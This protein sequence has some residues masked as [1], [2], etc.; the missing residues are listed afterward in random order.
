LQ[1]GDVSVA[2]KSWLPW[3]GSALLLLA[4]LFLGYMV[5]SVDRYVLAAVLKPMSLDLGIVDQAGACTT[6]CGVLS[7]AQYV[8]VALTVFAAGYLSDRYGTRRIIL[9]GVVV[10]SAFTWLVAFS[11]DFSQAFV[12]RLISGAGEGLFWP[13]AMSAAANYFGVRKGLALGIFY[14][15]FDVGQSTGYTIGGATYA[16]TSDWRTAFLVAPIMGVAVIAGAFFARG[17]FA[18]TNS[19][20]GRM[21][22]GRDAVDLLRRPAVV[23]L[24]TFALLATWS[25]VWQGVFLPYY[26][27]Q[28]LQLSVPA[29]AFL[30]ATTVP[31]AGIL[32]KVVLGGLSDRWRRDRLL[33]AL[34]AAVLV[35]YAI[36]FSTSNL[37]IAAASALAMGFFSAAIFPVMQSLVSDSVGGKTGTGLGLTT[38]TQSVA[39]VF[40]PTIAA[41]LFASGVGRALA[42]DA[43]VPAV[44]MLLVAFFLRE[45]RKKPE[46]SNP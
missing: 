34:S 26:Y 20:L 12:F 8:G 27:S 35:V 29:A 41:Y 18:E 44:L 36:F 3:G 45:P 42:L 9:V 39:T 37:V 30:A 13:V 10:F 21:A 32:G 25:S 4:I 28:V 15:G 43:M 1:G 5:Y 40:S 31:A 23:L 16:L 2:K 33:A 38:T 11:A 19:R 46:P 7:S 24:M 22:L 17:T 14:S 6:L